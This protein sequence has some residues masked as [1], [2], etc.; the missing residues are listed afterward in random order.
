MR[1]AAGMI[2][3]RLKILPAS[4][5]DPWDVSISSDSVTLLVM[6]PRALAYLRV[7]TVDQ[8]LGLGLDVQEA[9]VLK[10]AKKAGFRIVDV[11]KDEAISG[12]KGEDLRPGLAEALLRIQEGEADILL[13]PALDRLARDLFLQETV[14]R[15]LA[16]MGKRV[17]SVAEPDVMDGDGQRILVRQVL[18]AIAQYEASLIAARLRAGRDLKRARGGYA[19][20]RPPY[21]YRAFGG[22]LLPDANEQAVVKKAQRLRRRGLSFREI[23]RELEAGGTHSRTGGRW[24]PPQIARMIARSPDAR[25]S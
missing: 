2:R 9:T 12:T 10:H 16:E 1:E 11:V 23:A 13:I 21:G 8:T 15:K 25:A 17:E 6:K 20:G 14:I 24:H 19:Y 4:I 18:G 3:R 7:S 22:E 5:R